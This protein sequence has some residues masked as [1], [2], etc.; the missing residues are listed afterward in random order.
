MGRFVLQYKSFA[1]ASTMQTL[2][3]GL[4]AP[5]AA[6]LT[7]AGIATGFAAGS[8]F[9]KAKAGNWAVPSW[10]TEEGFWW[11]MRNSV[12]RAGFQGITSDMNSFLGFLTNGQATL[13]NALGLGPDR[14]FKYSNRNWLTETIGPTAS[15]AWDA[16]KAGGAVGNALLFNKQPPERAWNALRRQVWLNNHFLLDRL[17]QETFTGMDKKVRRGFADHLWTETKQ[18]LRPYYNIP[19]LEGMVGYQ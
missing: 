12:D 1:F 7:G 4:Q 14:E 16:W 6:F 2:I 19:D 10:D 13:G 5:N 3:P 15:T 11:W 17:Y 9:I 18:G 8:L